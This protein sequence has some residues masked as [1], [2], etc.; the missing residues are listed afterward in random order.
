MVEDP[1]SIIKQLDVVGINWYG[2]GRLSYK[3]VI[4][5]PY[6]YSKHF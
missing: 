2:T 3:F 5:I 6:I 1:Q 4:I